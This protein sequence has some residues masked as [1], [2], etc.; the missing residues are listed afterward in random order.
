MV[1]T[2]TFQDGF[3]VYF[4]D[5]SGSL[6]PGESGTVQVASCTIR[7]VR[8]YTCVAVTAEEAA[9]WRSDDSANPAR[10]V[11]DAELEKR[12]LRNRLICRKQTLSRRVF[13]FQSLSIHTMR[14]ER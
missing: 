4:V 8:G 7:A 13:P 10:G 6:K 9:F 14:Q 11:I 2:H 5:H 1:D 3:E 12:S